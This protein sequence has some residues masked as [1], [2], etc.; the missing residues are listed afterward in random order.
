MELINVKERRVFLIY[1]LFF[2]LLTFTDAALWNDGTHFLYQLVNKGFFID[3]LW[4]RYSD[5]IF[6]IP[7]ILS[8]K[9]FGPSPFSYWVF[10][11]TLYFIPL[12]SLGLFASSKSQEPRTK[13]FAWAVLFLVIPFGLMF[14]IGTINLSVTFG[15]MTLGLA[16]KDRLKSW[17]IVLFLL[18]HLV[19]LFGHDLGILFILCLIGH[20]LLKVKDSPMRKFLGFE[21]FF[22]L[23]FIAFKY[24]LFVANQSYISSLSLSNDLF[25]RFSLSVVLVS[26]ILLLS[27]KS[28]LAKILAATVLFYLSIAMLKRTPEAYYLNIFSIRLFLVPTV[29]IIFA[30]FRFL[31][32]FII[33][34]GYLLFCPVILVLLSLKAFVIWS[35][36]SIPDTS[37]I[38]CRIL[39]SQENKWSPPRW[40]IPMLSI[41]KQH[42]YKPDHI[43]A[44]TSLGEEGKCTRFGDHLLLAKGLQ[45]HLIGFDLKIDASNSLKNIPQAQF[46]IPYSDLKK[47]IVLPKGAALKFTKINQKF[48]PGQCVTINLQNYSNEPSEFMIEIDNESRIEDKIDSELKLILSLRKKLKE[49]IVTAKSSSNS[50]INVEKVTV[51]SCPQ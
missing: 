34:K 19:I 36:F 29:I 11:A 39:P 1:L 21:F 23:L 42:T 8:L 27:S 9:V 47:E 6:Q 28:K 51:E 40:T 33:P 50:G 49:V 4:N 5:F 2:F 18:C 48:V 31:P 7:T 15:T 22:L 25:S 14:P 37:F 10:K 20:Y 44:S 35:S 38:G 13:K 43:W 46:S 3:H 32:S 17:E 24:K 26:G 12:I 30:L 45:Y 16:L 41:L